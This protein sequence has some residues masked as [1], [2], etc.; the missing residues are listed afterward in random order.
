MKISLVIP[1]YNEEASIGACLDYAQKNSGGRFHEIIVVDNVCTD[2]TRAVAEAPGARVAFEPR[3]G[4]TR[5]RQCGL[6][7]ATG[8][9]IAYIDADT[10]LPPRWF[11]IAERIFNARPD[12]VCL[13]GPYRYFDG[14]WLRNK[15]MSAL[16]YSAPITYR[17]VG[18]MTLGGNFIA[19]KS[20]LLA[21]GGFDQTIDFYGE[22]TDI[23]RRLSKFGKVMFRMDFYMPTSARRFSAEGMVW[24]NVRYA[25]NYLWP[26][27]FHRPFSK[28]YKDIRLPADTAAKQS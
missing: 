10:R 6:N 14:S 13:S 7:A 23:A 9:L 11:D 18:Y 24:T 25:L 3:K 12:V 1:A 27:L 8:D 22:D 21:M 2:N 20:A 5:A 15:L 4:L 28:T 19:R 17:F 26:V 16:W